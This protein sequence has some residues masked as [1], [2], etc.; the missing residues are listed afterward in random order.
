[1]SNIQWISI[2]FVIVITIVQLINLF[3]FQSQSCRRMKNTSRQPV[4]RTSVLANNVKPKLLS[5]MKRNI[6]QIYVI[7]LI[8][9]TPKLYRRHQRKY[10]KLPI[11]SS[12]QTPKE[13]YPNLSGSSGH[14]FMLCKSCF[15]LRYRRGRNIPMG[16]PMPNQ[17][18]T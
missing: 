12:H 13:K 15:T 4:N 6:L 17:I 11:T 8:D 2:Q 5:K 18:T 3:V 7:T 14:C 1:M 9:F 16:I 10:P